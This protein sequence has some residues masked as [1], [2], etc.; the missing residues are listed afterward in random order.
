MTLR[1]FKH[2]A[3]AQPVRAVIVSDG[4]RDYVVELHTDTGA[5]LLTDWRGNRR[6]FRSLAD[7][8]RAVRG[9]HGVELAVRIA[10]DEACAGAPT[11]SAAFA[12]MPLVK[13][14]AA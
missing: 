9:A 14:Y 3:G 10:A 11:P 12:R 5:G 13:T 2:L 6:R 7:A 1:Q 4:C 8:K